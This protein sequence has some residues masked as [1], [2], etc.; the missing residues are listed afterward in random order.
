M[1]DKTSAPHQVQKSIINSKANLKNN[2]K[3][4]IG[5]VHLLMEGPE[6]RGE[7]RAA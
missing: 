7:P 3:K 5:R 6:Q 1:I 4:Q 2:N